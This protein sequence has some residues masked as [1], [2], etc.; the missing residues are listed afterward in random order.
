MIIDTRLP[1]AYGRGVKDIA[2]NVDVPNHGS[3]VLQ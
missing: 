2:D 1:E 3:N